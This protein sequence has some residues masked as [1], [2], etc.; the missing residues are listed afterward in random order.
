MILLYNK[1]KKII[2]SNK[3]L[4]RFVVFVLRIPDFYNIVYKIK[5]KILSW[6]TLHGYNNVYGLDP[7]SKIIL[8]TTTTKNRLKYVHV[9]LESIIRQE[10]KPKKI[11]LLLSDKIKREE[12]PNN[13][14]G[15]ESKGIEIQFCK[16]VGPHTKCYYTLKKYH[17]TNIAV[18]ADSDM[19]FS[20]DWLL[21]YMN[22]VIMK[23]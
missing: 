7:K 15:Y 10:V 21:I 12:I 16:D 4:F 11:I 1:V 13:I 20:S 22:I 9:M 5:Y 2:K 17:K 3:L 14:L 8:S 6:N 23:F 19:I 18:T